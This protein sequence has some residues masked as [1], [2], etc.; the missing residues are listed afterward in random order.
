MGQQSGSEFAADMKLLVLL[1]CLSASL[2]KVKANDPLGVINAILDTVGI[3]YVPPP[4]RPGTCRDCSRSSLARFGVDLTPTLPTNPCCTT[5]TTT[6]TS[7]GSTTTTTA[8]TAAA[9]CKCGREGTTRIVGG[10][11]STAGK[12]PWIIAVNFG[13]T[14]GSN[15]GGCAATL[16]ASNWAITAAH[17]VVDSGFTTKDSLSLVLGE[18]DLSSSTDSNDGNRKN[19]ML[20][21]DPIVHESYKSP[22]VNSNDI[23][24]L[25]LAEDVDLN[26]YTPACL[27]ASGADYTGQNGRVYGWGST[28]SCP[29]ATSNILLE[30]EVP[31][32]SDSVCEAASNDA[33]TIT[34]PGTGQCVTQAFSYSGQISSD[35]VCAGSS[36]KDA[37]QGDSGGPFTVKSSSTS[38]HDL[39]G[40]VS[41]GYGCAADSL[42]GV[43]AEV[44]Q[45]RTWIDEKIAANGGATFCS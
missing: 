21:L 32:V 36:G 41:W 8:T 31:I 1:L 7:S 30:V 22:N 14:D 24:L 19:V 39:V 9:T 25:K 44:A 15:P 29:A 23:A 4:A 42:Y 45:L 5:T 28:A 11:Q 34:D 43:Y 12:Y 6:P 20:A 35:M 10:E 13:S 26:T 3:S 27:A 33:V 37:C 16:V 2:S 38:Q 18:F 17:C 40:V